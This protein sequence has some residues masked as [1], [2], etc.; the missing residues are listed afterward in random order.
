MID[1]TLIE[2]HK[3]VDEQVDKLINM[4]NEFCT[5]EGV[6]RAFDSGNDK[7]GRSQFQALARAAGGVVSTEEIKAYI[8]YQVGRESR[9][10][11]WATKCGDKTFGEHLINA[12]K[13]VEQLV[14]AG[15][16]LA[17]QKRLALVE[18]FLGFLYW[19]ATVEERNAHEPSASNILDGNQ[20]HGNNN[21]SQNQNKNDRRNN[22]N[23]GRR[24]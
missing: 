3:T 7:I 13:K 6:A 23:A 4:V 9:P 15:D 16:P 22:S 14:D 18:R 19:R 21:R 1:N 8:A 5:V 11:K 24:R 17:R 10:I 20:G 2:I 12:I